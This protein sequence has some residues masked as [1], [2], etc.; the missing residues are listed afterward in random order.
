M[1]RRICT[2]KPE[3]DHQWAIPPRADE[4]KRVMAGKYLE[5]MR[6]STNCRK[7]RIAGVK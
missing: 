4:S 2:I 3:D 6:V 7:T 5:S 1:A